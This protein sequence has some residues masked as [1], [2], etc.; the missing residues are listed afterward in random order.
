MFLENEKTIWRER[1]AWPSPQ[2][3]PWLNV[4]QGET[5]AT[6]RIGG[7]DG[8]NHYSKS[9]SLGAYLTTDTDEHRILITG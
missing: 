2:G 6:H 3:I 5:Q 1:E 7:G 4:L 9:L 8:G